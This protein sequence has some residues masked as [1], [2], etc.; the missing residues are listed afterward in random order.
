MFSHCRGPN[1]TSIKQWQINIISKI[2]IKFHFGRI[3]INDTKNIQMLNHNSSSKN[4]VITHVTLDKFS[5]IFQYEEIRHFRLEEYFYYPNIFA[6]FQKT[7]VE[8][9]GI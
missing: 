3:C 6:Y 4:I 7:R 9:G 8:G 2:N 5:H 1:P